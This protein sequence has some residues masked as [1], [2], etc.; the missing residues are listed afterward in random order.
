MWATVPVCIEFRFEMRCCR[1]GILASAIALCVLH[2][3]LEVHFS[4]KSLHN[5]LESYA[6]WFN[7]KCSHYEIVIIRRGVISSFKRHAPPDTCMCCCG[8]C[9]TYLLLHAMN[10]WTSWHHEIF[11]H[12]FL[13]CLP[14]KL[15]AFVLQRYHPRFDIVN[16]FL[17]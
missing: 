11:F 9:E 1:T 14:I 2:P 13:C 10:F 15:F 3:A 4:H 6:V 17:L 8:G 16:C 5:T 7:N 12:F